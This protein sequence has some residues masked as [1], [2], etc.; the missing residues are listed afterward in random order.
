MSDPLP[1]PDT[2]PADMPSCYARSALMVSRSLVR[3][4]NAALREVGLPITQVSLLVAIRRHPTATLTSLAEGL[5]LERTTLLRN[6]R[7]LETT[8]FVEPAPSRGRPRHYRVTEAG[9]AALA[10]AY[11]AWVRMQR[12]L[13][14]A[15]GPDGETTLAALRHLRQVAGALAAATDPSA[16]EDT[17]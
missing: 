5:A 11:P 3:A 8:G 4:Y 10:R 6:M 16:D 7:Q 9:E 13:Q 1:W 15:L 12:T 17:P 2:L 14:E